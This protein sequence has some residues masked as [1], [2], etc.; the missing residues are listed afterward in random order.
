LPGRTP[1]E[2][3]RVYRGLADGATIQVALQKTFWST[4]FA[5]LV[6]R[7]GIPWEIDHEVDQGFRS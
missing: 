4:H 3:E 2:A 6:D 1:E 7:F 5:L